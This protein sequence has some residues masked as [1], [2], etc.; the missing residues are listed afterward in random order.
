VLAVFVAAVINPARLVEP[1]ADDAVEP[2]PCR[3]R[4]LKL[5]VLEF[6]EKVTSVSIADVVPLPDKTNCKSV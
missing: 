1:F 5:D 6:I 4:Q 2:L 3:T